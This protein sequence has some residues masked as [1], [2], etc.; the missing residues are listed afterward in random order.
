MNTE[1]VIKKILENSI[2]FKQFWKERGP[3][4][5]ALTSS[6]F[7]PVLLEPEEWIFSNDITAL[8]KALMQFEKRKMKVVKSAFNPEN[9][10]ILRPEMLSLWKINNFPEEWNAGICDLFVPEGHLTQMVVDAIGGD[11]EKIGAEAVETAFFACLETQLDLLGY[12]LFKPAESSK[13]AAVMSYLAEW[14]ADD[15]DAGL[16]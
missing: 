16:I 15:K 12:L 2:E 8:L 13:H 7:P 14:E 1:S 5:F 3:F 4:K 11:A 10:N 6:E 9:K